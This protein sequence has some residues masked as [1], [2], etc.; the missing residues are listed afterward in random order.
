MIGL[1]LRI[2]RV[3]AQYKGRIRLAAFFSFLKSVCSKGPFFVAFYIV[4]GFIN[5]TININMCVTAGLILIGCIALQWLFQ[6][7]ADHLQSATGFEIFADKRIEL[8]KHLR[9]L[10]MGFYS[11][12]NIGRISS[13]LS[14]DML[15]I[16]ENLMM[17]LADLISY[18]FSAIL[19]VI[20]M[21]GFNVWLGILSL[22]V[23]IV[24]YAIGEAMKNSELHHSDERQRASQELTDAVIEFTEGIGIIKTYNMV[25]ERSKVLTNSFT[26]SCDKSINFEKSH[27][28]WQ[29]ALNM[30]YAVGTAAILLVASYL[31]QVNAITLT[32]Y[33][34]FLFF[35]FELFGPLKAFYGQINRLTVMNSCLDRIEAVFQEPVLKDDGN[36]KIPETYSGREIEFKN[37]TF[38]YDQRDVLKD[39]SFSIEPNTMTALVGTSGGGK[40]TIANLLPRFWDINKGEILIRGVNIRDI[41]LSEL[42]NQIS[43]VFQRVYLF[44]DTIYNNIAMGRIDAS[45]EEVIEATRKARCYDFIMALPEGFDTVVGEGGASLSGGEQQRISIARCILKDTPIVILDEATAS[46]DAD[47]EKMIQEAISELVKGKTLLVIAHR[48]HTIVTA[49]Q[50]L[51]I[52]NG[53]IVESGTYQEVVSQG[54]VFYRMVNKKVSSRGFIRRKGE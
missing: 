53:E 51:V 20:F 28:P 52:N 33:I 35:V 24:M 45:Y 3:A 44:Q 26:T 1:M 16:E 43:M 34:G 42:M 40:S 23:S 47:N 29:I 6:N 2:L 30:T 12:G 36:K 32:Y 15:F 17:V 21:F 14:T 37:V 19:F 48:L 38:A 9:K 25:G 8:G 4:A 54:N 10:P 13:V 27:S 49:E 7:L 46:V 5:Q 39:I 41:P 22:M 18:L 11:E 31:Y 50:I